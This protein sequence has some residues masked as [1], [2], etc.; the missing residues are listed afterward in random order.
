MKC[1]KV[2]GAGRSF[3]E[4]ALLTNSKRTATVVCKEDCIFMTLSEEGYNNIMGAYRD[5]VVK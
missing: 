5:N 4:I 2:L 3:G 1:V